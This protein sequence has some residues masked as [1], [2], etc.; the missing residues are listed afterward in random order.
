MMNP[1]K[2]NIGIRA[3]LL[4]ADRSTNKV[5]VGAA[6]IYKNRIFISSNN[7]KSSPGAVKYYKYADQGMHAEYALFSRS[8]LDEL[9]IRGTV[10]IARRMSDKKSTGLAKPCHACRTMLSE[11]GITSIIYTNYNNTYVEEKLQ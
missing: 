11:L 4:G 2:I 10:F 3:A 6:M 9:P 7:K 1:K 8:L 5:K